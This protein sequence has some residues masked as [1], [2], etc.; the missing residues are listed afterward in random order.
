MW[1]TTR[2]VTFAGGVVVAGG[3]T[4]VN[5][6]VGGLVIE[7]LRLPSGG[8][9]GWLPW[10]GSLGL[11]AGLTVGVSGALGF[12]I[13]AFATRKHGKLDGVLRA[14]IVGTCAA[15]SSGVGAFLLV[16]HPFVINGVGLVASTTVVTFIAVSI[17]VGA[18]GRLVST[19]SQPSGAKTDLAQ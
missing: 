18:C 17:A 19:S 10:I 9:L 4:G 15:V 14:I 5:S 12:V 11:A 7:Q 1:T 13:G 3:I 8:S 2:I 16:V 6:A